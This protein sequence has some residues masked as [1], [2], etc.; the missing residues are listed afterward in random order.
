MGPE[1]AT[2]AKEFVVEPPKPELD[3]PDILDCS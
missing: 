1:G 3:S 2:D